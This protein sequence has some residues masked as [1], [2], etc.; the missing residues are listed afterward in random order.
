MQNET[1]ED[2]ESNAASSRDEPVV[3][4]HDCMI[5]LGYKKTDMGFHTAA[6]SNCAGC[7]RDRAILPIRHWT[8]NA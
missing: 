2:K 5:S 3:M 4:C 1:T 7:G 8:R 6:T